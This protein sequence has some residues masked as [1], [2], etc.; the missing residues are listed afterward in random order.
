MR[1]CALKSDEVRKAITSLE[2]AQMVKLGEGDAGT[3]TVTAISREQMDAAD[4]A[5]KAPEKKAKKQ[6][7]A[8][9]DQE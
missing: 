4:A 7:K 1:G 6:S 2:D 8:K 9:K 5:E 3:V